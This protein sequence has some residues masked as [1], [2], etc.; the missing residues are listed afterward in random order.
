MIFHSV[1][2][3]WII[4]AFSDILPRRG[5]RW[6]ACRLLS[7]Q[8]WGCLQNYHVANFL[9]QTRVAGNQYVFFFFE[10]PTSSVIRNSLSPDW[11][12]R[13]LSPEEADL[14]VKASQ[15]SKLLDFWAKCSFCYTNLANEHKKY[16]GAH[17]VKWMRSL[18]SYPTRLFFILSKSKWFFLFIS[19]TEV[20]N[21]KQWREELTRNSHK[22]LK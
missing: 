2:L 1:R 16:T 21:D 6:G 18:F 4:A 19:L 12:G 17:M 3:S 11:H 5:G 15:K 20:C 10:S 22:L 13:P 7:W 9:Y 8:D 14:V